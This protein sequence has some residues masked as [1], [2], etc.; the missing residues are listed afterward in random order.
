[1]KP[2]SRNKVAMFVSV[3]LALAVVSSPAFAAPP[4]PKDQNPGVAP[5]NSKPHGKNYPEWAAT[6]WKWVL[7]NTNS[8]FYKPDGDPS[9]VQCVEIEKNV[10]LLFGTFSQSGAHVERSCTV[11]T[12]SA[13]VF[14][15]I[16][17]SY[18]AWP[19]DPPETRTEPAV[20]AMVAGIKDSVQIVATIDGTSVEAPLNYF[21]TSTLFAVTA[22]A[23]LAN[24][25]GRPA[26]EVW[27]PSVDAGYYLFLHPLTPGQHT[28]AWVA[29]R[30]DPA[31]Q[32]AQD[33]LYTV[34]VKPG[35]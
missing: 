34:I 13:L 25:Y 21:E 10:W 14:P 29:T 12:G 3:F 7:E 24:P 9:Q 15:L 20:R 16:N 26:G 22:P 32:I 6:W 19:D 23:E 4:A 30:N 1:M 18:S 35:K 27:E 28:I 31:G 11:P 5:I 33:V 17:V 2:A 8:H